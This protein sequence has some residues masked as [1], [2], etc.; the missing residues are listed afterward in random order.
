MHAH[1]HTHA[2]RMTPAPS[3]TPPPRKHGS[4]T[5]AVSRTKPPPLPTPH[6]FTPPV[7]PLACASSSWSARARPASSCSHT[8]PSSGRACGSTCSITRRPFVNGPGLLRPFCVT[9]TTG[10][11]A[12]RRMSASVTEPATLSNTDDVICMEP[13]TTSAV[14][15]DATSAT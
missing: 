13:M 6:T 12:M 8:R 9:T 5:T 10:R 4:G 3:P 14:P 2:R 11:P 1:T 15:D 7:R